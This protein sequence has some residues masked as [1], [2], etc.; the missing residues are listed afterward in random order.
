MEN[1]ALRLL[2][3][4]FLCFS[5]PHEIFS[6]IDINISQ[7]EYLAARLD[8]F[9]CRRLIAALHYTSYELP[10]NLA[11]AE[12]T[13]DEDIPCLRQLVHWN[14]SPGEGLGQTHEALIHRLRQLN[15]NDLA[16]WLGKSTFKQ[17]G[18]DM[19][20]IMERPFDEL[21][22]Q[23]TE[24]PVKLT[25]APIESFEDND[26]STQIDVVLMAITLGL[27]GTV[28]ILIGYIIF[29]IIN[30]RLRK[31]KYRKVKERTS[32]EESFK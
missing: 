5:L 18:K 20:R 28:L 29:R 11:A 14:Q 13:V 15:R 23:E 4:I 24:I 12:R 10:M 9:E 1:F 31:A 22:L 30:M 2:G 8:P 7:L 32:T 21:G 3:Y 16:E 25:V 27:I 17:L 6:T 26:F 19:E